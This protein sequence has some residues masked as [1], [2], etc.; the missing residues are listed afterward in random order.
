MIGIYFK[1]TTS[2][3]GIT[4]KRLSEL[5][6]VSE[7]HISEFKTGKRSVTADVLWRLLTAM[8]E[9][10]PGSKKYFCNLLAGGENQPVNQP[11]SVGEQ[12]ER[13]IAA[14]DDEEIEAAMLAIAKK[15]R[16]KVTSSSL[17]GV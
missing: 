12:L 2:T 5:S 13:L 15:W 7:N 14:A 17:I 6:G 4:G 16:S 8:D 9:I 10:E 3:Y 1:K 11:Q